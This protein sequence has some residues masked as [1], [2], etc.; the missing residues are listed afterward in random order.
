MKE[1]ALENY[2]IRKCFLTYFKSIMD[3]DCFL[4][5][6]NKE[7]SQMNIE[8]NFLQEVSKRLKKKKKLEKKINN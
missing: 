5:C 7:R 3:K 6:K 1:I 4:K 8:I 2:K